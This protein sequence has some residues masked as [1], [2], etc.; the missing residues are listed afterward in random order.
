MTSEDFRNRRKND[1]RTYGSEYR[2]RALDLA[3]VSP[4]S[5]PACLKISD[6]H[7]STSKRKPR[8]SIIGESLSE[9]KLANLPPRADKVDSKTKEL[10]EAKNFTAKNRVDRKRKRVVKELEEAEKNRIKLEV[11]NRFK[12]ITRVLKAAGYLKRRVPTLN[13]IKRYLKKEKKLSKMNLDSIDNANV[14]DK[15]NE[16]V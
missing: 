12:D 5:K 13:Q 1:P 6:F 8:L 10:I 15:W 4:P 3:Q 11:E 7:S 2:L 16:F 14:V 9:A